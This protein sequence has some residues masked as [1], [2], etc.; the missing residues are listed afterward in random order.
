MYFCVSVS[1]ILHMHIYIYVWR[2]II[3]TYLYLLFI[4]IPSSYTGLLLVKAAA[5]WKAEHGGE[6][7]RSS[8]DRSAF[9]DLIRSWQRLFDDCPIPEE[10]FTEAI[11]NAHK[12]WA[13]PILSTYIGI[14]INRS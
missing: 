5:A 3:I 6:L 12:V 9:K 8:T 11:A 2:L 10:N 13:P 7:P 1:L 4:S 14:R